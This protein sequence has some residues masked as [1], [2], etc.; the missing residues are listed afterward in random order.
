MV[1]LKNC[2][3]GERESIQTDLKNFAN[4]QADD[5]ASLQRVAQ[6]VERYNG[7]AITLERARQCS[8]EACLQI[9]SFIDS[10]AKRSLLDLAAFVVQRRS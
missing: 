3:V 1:A 7:I 6:A 5:A 2:S 9:E 8:Q 10:N 4:S